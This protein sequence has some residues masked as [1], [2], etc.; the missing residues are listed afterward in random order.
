M[1]I[2]RGDSFQGTI[3]LRQK[4]ALGVTSPFPIPT[5]SLIEIHWPADSAAVVLSTVNS[6]EIT[7][8]DD[9]LT[10]ISYLGAPAKSLVMKVGKKLDVE[11][12][13]T[14]LAGIVTTFVK[15]AILE[16]KDRPN[17]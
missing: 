14:D 16:V 13:V 1:L 10:T 17:A 6:G 2:Y 4:S 7:V 8:V 15:S 5:G 3:Q 9:A 11:I 12:V